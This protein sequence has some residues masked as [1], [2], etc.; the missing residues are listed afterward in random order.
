MNFGLLDGSSPTGYGPNLLG[1][2]KIVKQAIYVYLVRPSAAGILSHCEYIFFRMRAHAS[3]TASA[4]D[5]ASAAS[6]PQFAR[7]PRNLTQYLSWPRIR[8]ARG[9][10]LRIRVRT[11]LRSV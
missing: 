10:L 1:L 3:P 7:R 6:V 9:Q 5:H 8:S 2:K 4:N 11:L